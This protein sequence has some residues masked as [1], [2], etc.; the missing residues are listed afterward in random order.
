MTR[1]RLYSQLLDN[2]NKAAAN[3]I[4]MESLVDYLRAA[5]IGGDLSSGHVEEISNTVLAYREFCARG[6]L[7]DFSLCLELFRD[8]IR[9]SQPARD[10]LFAQHRHL[11]YDNCEEDIFLAHDLVRLWL[12]HADSRLESAL[13]V[14]DSDAGFRKFLAANPASAH[15]LKQIC[16][17]YRLIEESPRVPASLQEFGRRL[18]QAIANG[19]AGEEPG[20]A[21]GHRRL[22]VFSDRLH[23]EMVQRV[24]G[25]VE[26]LVGNGAPPEEIAVISPFLSDSLFHALS[27]RLEAAGIGY[28][29]HRPSVAEL[30]GRAGY[31]GAADGGRAC[32]PVLGGAA[33]AGSGNAHVPPAPGWGGPGTGCGAGVR[34][35]RVG[36]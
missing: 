32:P 30:A 1:S 11:V 21:D 18:G 15:A 2:L 3:D 20:G 19:A 22:H 9:Q 35:L 29:M 28:Y 13:I 25:Q 31:Q 36:S 6:N 34:R 26:S 7:L 14:Y 10:Y 24:A 33:D 16:E 4:P 17:G 5:R 27:M 23:H 12:G 8:L